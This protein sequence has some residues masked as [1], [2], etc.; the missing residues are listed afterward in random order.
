MQ[1]NWITSYKTSKHL[2][3]SGYT[4]IKG[5]TRKGEE[6]YK[7]LNPAGATGSTYVFLKDGKVVAG[8]EKY[9][10][11]KCGESGFVK[12]SAKGKPMKSYSILTKDKRGG[13][14]TITR[15]MEEGTIKST[16]TSPKSQV[17]VRLNTMG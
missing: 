4:K 12:V 5:L 3:S 16:T 9:S 10:H 8:L 1:N 2:L 15:N 14:Y 11:P 6:V 17:T 7:N 13:F